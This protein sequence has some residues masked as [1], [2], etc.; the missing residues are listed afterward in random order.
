MCLSHDSAVVGRSDMDAHSS[1]ASI[2]DTE[3]ID[4]CAHLFGQ[5]HCVAHSSYGLVR[6]VCRGQN[7]LDA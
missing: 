2:N 5:S 1:D 3:Q 7:A 6:K 4:D